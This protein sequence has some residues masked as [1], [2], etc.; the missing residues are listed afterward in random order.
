MSEGFKD[1]GI[2]KSLKFFNETFFKTK[3]TKSNSVN[4]KK[5]S[6]S[7]EVEFPVQMNIEYY[8][9]SDHSVITDK[10]TETINVKTLRSKM[11]DNEYLTYNENTLNQ[12]SNEDVSYSNTSLASISE[13]MNWSTKY[14][15]I[16]L[17]PMD[18]AY[19]EDFQSYPVNR[20]MVLRRFGERQS[21][22][23]NLFAGGGKVKPIS[24]MVGYYDML[25]PGVKMSFGEKWTTFNDTFFSLIQDIIGLDFATIPGMEKLVGAGKSSPL[26]QD[27]LYHLGSKLGFIGITSPYGE[28]NLIH[29]AA[30]REVDGESLKTGLKTDFKFTFETIYEYRYIDGVDGKQ[31]LLELIENAMKMGTSKAV[32]LGGGKGISAASGFFNALQSGNLD[33]LIDTITGILSTVVYNLVKSTKEVFE[34]LGMAGGNSKDKEAKNYDITDFSGTKKIIEAIKS[35]FGAIARA[36]GARYKWKIIASLGT[37][38]GKHTAPWHIS[39]GN[40]KSPWFSMGNLVLEDMTIEPM[41]EMMFDDFPSKWKITAQLKN[42]RPMGSQELYRCFKGNKMREY[43]SIEKVL[44][45][46]VEEGTTVKYE[47]GLLITPPDVAPKTHKDPITGQI[48]DEGVIN[49]NSNNDMESYVDID[50]N[51]YTPPPINVATISDNKNSVLGE[52]LSGDNEDGE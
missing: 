18:I 3:K 38:S 52:H 34:T 12:L 2:D 30:T 21:V 31:S 22:P 51:T 27:F 43:S 40:P 7:D 32:F 17:K 47:N 4:N 14:P 23:H 1:T 35:G 8:S 15:Q 50:G 16:A 25:N 33:L 5:I 11:N 48:T 6:D 26:A 29:E 20:F 37:L 44:N 39:L 45:I 24:T 9:S 46:T 13:I 10:K 19:L 36:R 28:A 42:G 49:D 41:G